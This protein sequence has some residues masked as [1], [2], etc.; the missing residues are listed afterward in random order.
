MQVFNETIPKKKFNAWH[1]LLC[2]TNGTYI[3]NPIVLDETVIVCY[4]PGDYKTQSI[5]W[6]RMTTPIKEVNSTQFWK[7]MLRKV[8][9][10]RVTIN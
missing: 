9:L 4:E 5:A 3:R 1:L 7:K 10:F 2:Q 8:K 6:N